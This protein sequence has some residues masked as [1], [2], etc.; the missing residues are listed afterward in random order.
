MSLA[1]AGGA[2][3]SV[4]AGTRSAS[5]SRPEHQVGRRTETLS[6]PLETGPEMYD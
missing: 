5:R 1:L 3:S 2:V 4:D 6:V